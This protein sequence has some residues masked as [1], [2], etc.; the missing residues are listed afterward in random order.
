MHFI[1]IY[2]LDDVGVIFYSHSDW[3]IYMHL[4]RQY[5]DKEYEKHFGVTLV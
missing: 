4:R 2:F 5:P 3:R 1:F